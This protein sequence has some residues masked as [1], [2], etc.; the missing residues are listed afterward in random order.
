M[1]R[2]NFMNIIFWGFSY[3]I[4]AKNR[5][6]VRIWQ[7]YAACIRKI[8]IEKPILFSNDVR[9]EFHFCNDLQTCHPFW[10]QVCN[11]F[12]V[13]DN[14]F[15]VA[16]VRALENLDWEFMKKKHYGR[17]YKILGKRMRSLHTD[18]TEPIVA[19]VHSTQINLE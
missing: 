19:L 1:F 5:S 17:I 6:L 2:S 4:G 14:V 11:A 15:N 3:K 16:A 9:S 8:H 18:N 7:F 10:L 12:F 13:T